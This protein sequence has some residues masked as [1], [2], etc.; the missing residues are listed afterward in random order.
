MKFTEELKRRR[1]MKREEVAKEADK[2]FIDKHKEL[3]AEL[4]EVFLE[5]LRGLP[6]EK[7]K[8]EAWQTV[9][10]FQE[11]MEQGSFCLPG[12]RVAMTETRRALS[13]SYRVDRRD[14]RAAATTFKKALKSVRILIKD[15]G[16]WDEFQRRLW[17]CA[18]TEDAKRT[19]RDLLVLQTLSGLEMISETIQA[20]LDEGTL[21]ERSKWI[22]QKTRRVI[23]VRLAFL[24]ELSRNPEKVPDTLSALQN[25]LRT[26]TKGY[27]WGVGKKTLGNTFVQ[28]VKDVFEVLGLTDTSAAGALSGTTIRKDMLDAV[29]EFEEI[30]NISK[31]E[32]P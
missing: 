3:A 12:E 1:G 17:E 23:I 11:Y 14:L 28:F 29:K 31:P 26:M 32:K 20:M 16:A 19:R 21:F 7:I 24:F 5:K 18:N 6:P 8:H 10:W 9:G 25:S 27:D 4:E 22:T 15:I 2:F 13:H 30:K